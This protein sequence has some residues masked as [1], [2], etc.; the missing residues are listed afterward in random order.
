MIRSGMATFEFEWLSQ[1]IHD[2]TVVPIIGPELYGALYETEVAARLASELKLA[3]LPATATPRDVALAY[4]VQKADGSPAVLKQTL[5]RVLD[6][7]VTTP[8]EPLRQL[9]QIRDLK[10]YV[11]TALDDAL[12]KAL[13]AAGRPPLSFAHSSNVT[14]AE[15]GLPDTRTSVAPSVCHVLGRFP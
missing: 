14:K 1:G 9:A 12:E 13:Q 11:T 2:G 5:R 15:M 7:V 10:L 8:P 4:Q 3:P 6:E